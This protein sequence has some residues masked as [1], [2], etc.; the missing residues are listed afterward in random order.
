[1]RFTYPPYPA[2]HMKSPS[3]PPW[4]WL[5]ASKKG[6]TLSWM[7]VSVLCGGLLAI[8]G[9]FLL[10]WMGLERKDWPWNSL[11]ALAAAPPLLL[12]WYW[13]TIHRQQELD[14]DEEHSRIEEQ[15]LLTERFTRAIE[16]LGSEKLQIRLGGIYA[17]ERIARDSLRDHWTV[18]ETLCAFARE[19]TREPR[20]A[21]GEGTPSDEEDADAES[22]FLPPATDVQAALTVMGRRGEEGRAWEQKKGKELDLRGVH[23]EQAN[24]QEAHFEGINLM[25]AY[26]ERSHLL[27][28]HLE[29]AYLWEANLNRSLLFDAH[30]NN[31]ELRGAYLQR[32][33]CQRADLRG[34][35][36]R[37]AHL[38]GANLQD[39]HL[40]GAFL[41]EA[42]LE[43][44]NLS[45][46]KGLT[47]AQIDDAILDE[48]TEL[49]EGI[50]RPAAEPALSAAA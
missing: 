1:M 33:I 35:D 5:G 28:I 24:L 10:G 9:Y 32:S 40:E 12:T 3:N 31:A 44:T 43:G 30:L 25:D 15:R 27:G 50:T 13:R 38:E 20:R 26:L 7:A 46:A 17:L 42:H 37:K 14:T 29:E 48:H 36:L 41:W 21:K 16:L 34:T 45:G 6:K 23:L 49:P 11:S 19:G 47:Q 4:R 18:M 2:L 39:A 22:T 8:G